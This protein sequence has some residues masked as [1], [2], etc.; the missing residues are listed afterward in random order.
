MLHPLNPTSTPLRCF[1]LCW[2]GLPW[3]MLLVLT[4]VPLR[5]ELFSVSASGRITVN[6][7]GDP[8]IPV[9]TPWT[10]ELTYDTASPDLDLDPTHGL[11]MNSGAIPAL[12]SFHYRAGSY[13]VTVDDPGDFGPFSEI[14]ITFLG[15]AHA[16]DINLN[17]AGLFPPLAGGAVN[18]HADFNSFSHPIF[19]SDALPTDTSLGIDDFRGERSVTLLPPRGV[20]LGS[21]QDVTNFT[22]AAVPEPST[23]GLLILGVAAFL[24]DPR[25]RPG[26]NR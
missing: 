20:V 6:D 19:T 9:G 8:T 15:G 10:F 14:T 1:K 25:R 2:S 3:I 26:I 23:C 21:T 22:I 18:F 7:T 5:A 24:A 4:A 11:Y 16:I 17:A 13:E 12:R